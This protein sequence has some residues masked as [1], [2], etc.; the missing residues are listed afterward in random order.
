MLRK[1]LS[2]FMLTIWIAAPGTAV[3]Q[4]MSVGGIYCLTGS[5][6]PAH[7]LLAKVL[8]VDGGVVHTR[9]YSNEFPSCPDSVDTSALFWSI[10][11]LPVREKGFLMLNPKLVARGHVSA[12]EV[13]AVGE[14]KALLKKTSNAK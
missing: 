7:V 12:E 8:E 4:E 5:G 13:E 1:A 10:P 9:Q 2:F 3:G 14:M 6:G 11:D